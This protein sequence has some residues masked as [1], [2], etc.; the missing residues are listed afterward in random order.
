MKKIVLV[1]SLSLRKKGVNMCKRDNRGDF[2][3]SRNIFS[4]ACKMKKEKKNS[5]LAE[6]IF[7]KYNL[8]T[9]ILLHIFEFKKTQIN[10]HCNSN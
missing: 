5:C 2:A 8:N 1:C 9:P 3:Y 6:L 10:E 4:I 7:I